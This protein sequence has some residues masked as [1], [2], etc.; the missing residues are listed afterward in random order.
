LFNHI[1]I[2]NNQ[3]YISK[4]LEEVKEYNQIKKTILVDN[5]QLLLYLIYSSLNFKF[6][7]DKN[8]YWSFQNISGA[9]GLFKA[10]DTMIKNEKNYFDFFNKLTYKEFNDF[11]SFNG[12]EKLPYMKIR[13]QYVKEIIELLRDSFNQNIENLISYNNY[14]AVKIV[15]YLSD[16]TKAF[17]DSIEF[18]E[19]KIYLVKKATFF[20]K[21]LIQ[22]KNYNDNL[23]NIDKLQILSD[24][25]VPQ[26]LRHFKIL[27]YS[28]E[29][30]YMVDNQQILTEEYEKEIRMATIIFSKSLIDNKKTILNI[31]ELDEY[32]WKKAK[33][34]ERSHSKSLKPFHLM[35][36]TKY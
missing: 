17:S 34:L 9:S 13:F 21:L 23:T 4:L 2:N 1:V 11:L 29:L 14:D 5:N 10:V 33:R 30:S 31:L 7:I 24:Y 16:N 32:L 36:S 27:E 6:W 26:L 19:K 3:T 12:S 22:T 8:N 18:N 28:K 15:Q 20:I 35:E 25:R